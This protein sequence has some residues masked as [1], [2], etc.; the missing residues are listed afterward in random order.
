[1][2]ARTSGTFTGTYKL[3]QGDG[4]ADFSDH[5]HDWCAV[6]KQ[7]EM[8]AVVGARGSTEFG[9]FVSLGRL[10]LEPEPVLTLA[11][12]YIARAHAR[13]CAHTHGEEVHR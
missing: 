13:T 7:D 8:F 1:M 6:S 2:L 4:L 10:D 12:R 5:S 3:D 9:E 11:R